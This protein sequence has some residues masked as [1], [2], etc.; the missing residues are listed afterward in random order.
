LTADIQKYDADAM[1][2]GTEM[3]ELDA[4]I[5]KTE[6]EK[7]EATEERDTAKADY[8]TKHAELSQSI[9]ELEV[10]MA[11]LKSMMG[12][13][14]AASLIQTMSSRL[15]T[16]SQL[17]S[18]A[19][20]L[21]TSF[22]ETSSTAVLSAPE[23]AVFE[24]QSGGIVDM[25]DGLKDK[26]EDE[27]TALEKEEMT[28][29]GSYDMI[30]QTLTSTISEHSS[31]RSMKAK[32]TKEKEA[33]SSQAAGEKADTVTGKAEDEKYLKD[34]QSEC[35]MKASDYEN[36]QKL[37]AGEIGA[38]NKAIEIISGGAVSGASEKHLPSL[39]QVNQ[40]PSL[41]QLRS[42]TMRPA[43]LAVASFLK[44]QGQRTNSRILSMLAVRA[45]ED[46]FAKIKK[47]IQ[48][49]VYKLMEEANEEA[50]HK[51]FCDAE[52]GKNK[53]TRDQKGTAVE[54]LTASI[55]EMGAHINRLGEQIGGLSGQ[56]AELNA[57]VV[58]ATSIRQEEKT[59][60]TETITEAKAAS[61]AVQK[62]LGVLQDFYDK[63]A[64]A[65][66]VQVQAPVQ[67]SA[68]GGV[69][70][71]LEVILSDFERLEANT[72]I[73]EETAQKEFEKFTNESS[74]DKAVK[75]TQVNNMSEEK[76]QLDVDNATAQKDLESTQSELD[77]ALEYYEKLKPSC[78][79]EVESYEDRVARRKEEIESLKDALKILDDQPIA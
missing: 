30:A 61:S 31:A 75:D 78:V 8:T 48:D 68:G 36:N 23:G 19:Q 2:L 74:M 66:L 22:L 3:T 58:E 39:A 57:A 72:K 49:M 11:Q 15:A 51:G 25:M 41:A 5:D 73:A 35:A 77:A 17:P 32:T 40:D 67:A 76:T 44:S 59:K 18:G 45:A 69:I 38:L 34:V 20:R 6:Q 10:G 47:M 28:A 63:A 54:E 33:A 9:D 55:E 43:Q 53:M 64:G 24:S 70:G 7:A 62:A 60:N 13:T 1:T 27:K 42:S 16:R 21:L 37:R 56:L 26:M 14:N 71:M 29:Q 52:M 46:P 4:S 79:Q 65:S 12:G 50:E